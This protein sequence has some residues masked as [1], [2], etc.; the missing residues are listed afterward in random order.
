MRVSDV[1]IV[2]LKIVFGAVHRNRPG[3]FFCTEPHA[4]FQRFSPRQ[5][6][7]GSMAGNAFA[8]AASNRIFSEVWLAA[9]RTLG[10]VEAF[11]PCGV[12]IFSRH[13]ANIAADIHFAICDDLC[14]GS[15]LCD[16]HL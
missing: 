10:A 14:T 4:R 16:G 13:F 3:F 11:L 5:A 15:V 9:S 2:C 7:D 1:V 12:C 6:F 8:T